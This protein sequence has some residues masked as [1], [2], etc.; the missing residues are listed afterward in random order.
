MKVRQLVEIHAKDNLKK[1]MAAGSAKLVDK[2]KEITSNG[3]YSDEFLAKLVSGGV[4]RGSIQANA[5]KFIEDFHV[6]GP[7]LKATL[8]SMVR[9][10]DRPDLAQKAARILRK[11]NP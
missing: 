5:M 10:Q 9:S 11:R 3:G 8:E 7:H 4:E 6:M 1:T 2:V